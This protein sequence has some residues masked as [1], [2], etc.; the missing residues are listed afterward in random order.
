MKKNE[1]L[2]EVWRN[3]DEFAREHNY[4]LDAMVAALQEMEKHPLNKVV[5]RRQKTSDKGGKG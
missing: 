2:E 4:D 1:I 3:R 5:D